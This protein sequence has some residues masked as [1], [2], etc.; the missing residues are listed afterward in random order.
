[1]RAR[2]RGSWEVLSR[3]SEGEVEAGRRVLE[4]RQVRDDEAVA[5]TAEEDP[6]ERQRQPEGAEQGEED[7]RGLPLRRPR[8]GQVAAVDERDER[9]T[10]E[11]EQR[12]EHARDRRVE[13]GEELLKPEE[14][15]RR[16]GDGRRDVAVRE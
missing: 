3:R 15:P 4:E 9:G 12:G 5:G 16:F 13:V 10:D 6:D 2:F 1:M 8:R 7:D 14:V 11:D